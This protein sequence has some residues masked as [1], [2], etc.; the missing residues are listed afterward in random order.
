MK[1]D[2]TLG[3][4]FL[5]VIISIIVCIVLWF[6]AAIG[7]MNTTDGCL[8][9]Y[10]FVPGSDISGQTLSNTDTIT[11][12]I[13]LKANGNYSLTQTTV[14]E[15]GF[16][17]DPNE[18]GKWVNTNII[19]ETDQQIEVEVRGE[20]SLCKAYVPTHNLQQV[21]N[22]D[23]DNKKIAIPRV[24]DLDSEPI[25][26]IFDA[27]TDEWRNITELFPNDRYVVAI[28]PNRKEDVAATTREDIFTG[29]DIVADCRA[30]NTS[31]NP[32]CG[33]FSIY[34]GSFV[35]SCNWNSDC[36]DCNCR[37]KC[38]EWNIA[39]IICIGGY[40]TVCD[41]CG[42]WE[43]VN[44]VLP[45]PY[46]N[47]GSN[48]FEW[49]DNLNSLKQNY[50]Y[51]C[52]SS[53]IYINSSAY[54]NNR[55][56]WYSA[57]DA[58]G[59]VYRY[60]GSENPS[61]KNQLG[62]NYQFAE[63]KDYG[64][65][66]SFYG[67]DSVYQVLLDDTCENANTCGNEGVHYLQY[68]FISEN[69][70]DYDGHTG[71]YVLNIKQTK[72]RRSNGIGVN[73]SIANRGAVEYVIM[74]YEQNP[75]DTAPGSATTLNV[76]SDGKGTIIVPANSEG[77]IWMRIKN[78]P[79]DYVDS[80]G[81]YAVEFTL[82]VPRDSFFEKILNPLVTMLKTKIQ[83]AAETIFKNM[84]CYQG[85]GEDDNCTNFFDYIR[86]M[87]TLYIIAYGFLFLLGNVQISQTD[88]VIRVIK[89]GFVAGLMNEKTFTFFN[90]YVFVFVTGFSD[91]IISNMGGYSIFTAGS[92]INNPFS[93]LSSVLNKVFLSQTFGAQMMALLALGMNGVLYFI[94]IFVTLIMLVI[95]LFRAITVYMMAFMALAVLIG[96]A[97][98]FLTFMLF[99]FTWY[100]FDNWLKFTFRYMIEPVIMLAGII[101]LTQ[102][103]T[104]YLDQVVGYSI[105][106]KCV[107]P[108]KIPFPNIPGLD[109]IFT[110]I[111][112]FCI[113]WFAPWGFDQRTGQMGLNMQHIA[114]LVM[115]A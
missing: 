8:Y 17:L 13:T 37:R 115:L 58:A 23:S 55:K 104:I 87:L 5:L 98:L 45:D 103:F 102:L 42:C 54:Q 89:V 21:S 100:L 51:T 93:F 47:D 64:D 78:D 6:I 50:T 56:F 84:T 71:G 94:I 91:D 20:A 4:M 48:S 68:R 44:G 66:I 70:A 28:W 30:G 69:P 24:D 80:F 62:S 19:T 99:N 9:R 60:D 12:T 75:N 7:A 114:A 72:C 111:E 41:R 33:K 11:Q 79:N 15:A 96:L 85:A 40:H 43:N 90:D 27:T 76:S 14:G 101:I 109:S 57:D 110:D 52:S 2:D 77:Y 92:T 3:F 32:I 107:I 106:W 35:D 1:Q 49:S 10:S 22:L 86:A 38:K 74:P 26:L 105:C 29:N 97:P 34:S 88:I 95:V 31:Y 73:D 65:Q 16:E 81:Q 59:L 67:D 82:N 39:G 113:N 112:I 63:I 83:T 46:L 61:S 18:Y 108:V 53:A 25:S 36:Y